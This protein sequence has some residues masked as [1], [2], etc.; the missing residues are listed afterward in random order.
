MKQRKYIVIASMST[1]IN[2][3]VLAYGFTITGLVLALALLPAGD[4]QYVQM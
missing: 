4:V 2:V 3:M 1:R